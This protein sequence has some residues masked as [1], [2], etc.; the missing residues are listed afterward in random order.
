MRGRSGSRAGLGGKARR[1]GFS[2]DADMRIDR[3]AQQADGTEARVRWRDGREVALRLLVP[4]VHNLRNAVAALAAVEALG[5]A[6][7]PAAAALAEFRGVGGG[8]SAWGST[9]E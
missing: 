4:G 5:G 6:L 1:F 8:S 3:V 2:A 7:E 9:G